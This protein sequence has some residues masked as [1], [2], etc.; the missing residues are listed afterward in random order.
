MISHCHHD[1]IAFKELPCRYRK[2]CTGTVIDDHHQL[3][4]NN[5]KHHEPVWNIS[6]CLPILQRGTRGR[7]SANRHM[8]QVSALE[9][10]NLSIKGMNGYELL[11][12][13]WCVSQ[14]LPWGH[15]ESSSCGIWIF[16]S[17]WEALAVGNRT[18]NEQTLSKNCPFALRT[19]VMHL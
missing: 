13:L 19:F 2:D 1:I 7:L 3:L 4:L 9:I 17:P 18:F 8:L 6:P 12:F 10:Y 15:P 14:G 11:M 5:T 16:G